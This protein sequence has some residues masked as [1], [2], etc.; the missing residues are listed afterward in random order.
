MPAEFKRLNID[1]FWIGLL[2]AIYSMATIFLGPFM[3]KLYPI[4]GRRKPIIIGNLL[5]GVTFVI[6][7]NMHYIKDQV[8]YIIIALLIRFL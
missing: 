4:I 5:L 7:G 1:Q 6:Y 8:I 2:F 3:D